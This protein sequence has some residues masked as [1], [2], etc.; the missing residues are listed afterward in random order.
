[1]AAPRLTGAPGADTVSCARRGRW[2]FAG[3]VD[4]GGQADGV[5]PD[6]PTLPRA[7]GQPAGR[8][9]AAGAAAGG[10]RPDGAAPAV[11]GAR[12]D[13]AGPGGEVPRRRPGRAESGRG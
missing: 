11:A 5:E 2:P 6:A 4:A 8:D 7:A 13:A 10:G 1:M 3:A 12:G 9:R